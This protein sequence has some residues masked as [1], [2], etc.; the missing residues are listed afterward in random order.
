MSGTHGLISFGRAHLYIHFAII[1][2]AMV[3]SFSVNKDGKT[4]SDLAIDFINSLS[5]HM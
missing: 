2:L 5:K 3:I 4:E 1:L